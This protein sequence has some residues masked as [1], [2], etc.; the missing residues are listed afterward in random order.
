M[1]PALRPMSAGDWALMATLGVL[2]SGSYFFAA[3]AVHQ[4]PP[5]TLALARLGLATTVLAALARASGH[6]FPRAAR[7]WGAFAATGFLNAALP[8]TLIFWGQ[9]H[10]ASSLTAILM[11]TGPLFTF[12]CAHFATRDERLTGPKIVGV[13]LGV[14]GAAVLIGIEALRDFGV[15]SLA[16]LAMLAAALSYAAAAVLSRQFGGL[17]PLVTAVGQLGC[18]ALAILPLALIVDRPWDLPPPGLVALAATL[19][20]A[21]LT[22]A[23]GYVIYFRLLRRAG[24]SN[25]MLVSF[26]TP[27]GSSILGVLVLGEH[28]A[29]HNLAGMGLI[30][31][32]LALID[33]RVLTLMRRVPI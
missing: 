21:L 28:L 18:A 16:E 17:P 23:L 5:F 1:I 32:G 26:L 11:A 20:L 4:I 13:G 19:C 15:Q 10:I 31:A 30:F 8:F 12:V 14:L 22:T 27:I 7:I 29:P 25:V 24:A 6:A 2:W 9:R 33:G 3:L